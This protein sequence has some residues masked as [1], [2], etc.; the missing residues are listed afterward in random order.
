MIRPLRR[1]H[2]RIA[3][4]LWWAPILVA[5]AMLARVWR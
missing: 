5:S 2:A 4:A 1:A 3:H